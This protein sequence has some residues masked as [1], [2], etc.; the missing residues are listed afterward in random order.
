M[1][2]QE[3]SAPSVALSAHASES[4]VWQ[5]RS[6]CAQESYRVEDGQCV[7]SAIDVL[8]I[9]AGMAGSARQRV[10]SE[11]RIFTL[12]V[13]YD[14]TALRYR[15][16][17]ERCENILVAPFSA[18]RLLETLRTLSTD[19]TLDPGV[20][21]NLI[22]RS[23]QMRSL[24]RIMSQAAR[25]DATVLIKGETGTGKELVA[26]GI[27]YSSARRDRAF[28]PVNCGALNDELLLAEL[29]GHE[30]GAFTD[31]KRTHRGLVDQASG[32]VLFLD[33]IDSLSPRGQAAIL[34]FLQE[35]EYRPV[36][37]SAVVKANARVVAASNKDLPELVARAR[38]REDLYYRLN[39]LDI[40]VPPLR[41]R[42]GDVEVLAEDILAKLSVRHR[43]PPKRLHPLTRS[44]MVE[45][46]WP[47][48][49]RELQNF[50]YRVFV[51]CREEIILVPHVKG[52]PIAMH[53]GEGTGF[54][55]PY[56]APREPAA[57]PLHPFNR[58]RARALE[59]FERSY[60]DRAMRSSNGNVSLAA[61]RA[62]KERRTFRR[63]LKKYGM[64]RQGYA[65]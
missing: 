22:G 16:L 9:G 50:L 44:W 26:R 38:F 24:L 34:R 29:F 51:R 10:Q 4:E 8:L 30:K 48:N 17:L 12:V 62:G 11:A 25:Y 61:R 21:V 63:L 45:Y 20:G 41:L 15:E 13:A 5:F 56:E 37:S 2:E 60:L 47:G 27:H 64:D 57:G 49:V 33:E 54:A 28:V 14:E 40:V 31:A 19:A 7:A 23:P 52:D 46:A 35:Q 42:T 58:E 55:P 53:G 36:G 6:I 39:L 32:G 59:Q 1:G 43:T 65:P 3:A 18:E